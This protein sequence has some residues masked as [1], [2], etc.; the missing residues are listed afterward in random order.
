MIILDCCSSEG[1]S[2]GGASCV[3]LIFDPLIETVFVEL[4]SAEKHSYY[5]STF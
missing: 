4:V 5:R 3:G 2:A 1:S